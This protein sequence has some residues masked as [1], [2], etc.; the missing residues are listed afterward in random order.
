MANSLA[1]ILY[2]A[3]QSEMDQNLLKDVGLTYFGI[4]DRKVELVLPPTLAFLIK[5]EIIRKRSSFIIF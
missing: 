4:K 1:R 2:E 3:L 5:V